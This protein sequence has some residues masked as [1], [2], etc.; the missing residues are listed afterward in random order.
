VPPSPGTPNGDNSW[1]LHASTSPVA[2]I[3]TA[4]SLPVNS[5][6]PVPGP[7]AVPAG[8][9]ALRDLWEAGHATGFALF[10]AAPVQE[11][12]AFEVRSLDYIGSALTCVGR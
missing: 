9:W 1:L 8:G 4:A 10:A 11:P 5:N 7:G 12:E 3:N 2:A 6:F